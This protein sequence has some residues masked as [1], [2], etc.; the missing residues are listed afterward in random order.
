[1][2]WNISLTTRAREEA[3][4]LQ[5]R[6]SMAIALAVTGGVIVGAGV[7]SGALVV[8]SVPVSALVT[9]R[10]GR[11]WWPSRTARDQTAGSNA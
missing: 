6:E 1:M 7:L 2:D 8:R 4:V 3:T 11:T 10:G 9:L 5:T